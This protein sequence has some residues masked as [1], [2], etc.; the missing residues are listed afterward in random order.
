MSEIKTNEYVVNEILSNF[1]NKDIEEVNKIISINRNNI[2]TTKEFIIRNTNYTADEKILYIEIVEL[3]QN[4]NVGNKQKTTNF[5]GRIYSMI[6]IDDFLKFIRNPN[7][8]FTFG[9]FKLLLAIYELIKSANNLSNCLVGCKK[10]Y[11]AEQAG[12]EYKNLSKV[13][14]SLKKKEIIKE[15]EN[16]SLFINY[17]YFYMGNSLAYDVFKV[18]FDN[19]E[20]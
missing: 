18:K 16:G 12:I 8:N 17:K 15:D 11:L 9:E 20:V 10:K 4:V 14:N 19:L 3:L 13:F 2:K 5:D 6:F 7:N 1:E